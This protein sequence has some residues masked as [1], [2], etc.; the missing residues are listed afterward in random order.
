MASEKHANAHLSIMNI[1]QTKFGECTSNTMWMYVTSINGQFMTKL[2][3][4]ILFG[5]D[6]QDMRNLCEILLCYVVHNN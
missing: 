2:V 6:L 4:M 1:T 5:G 3:D